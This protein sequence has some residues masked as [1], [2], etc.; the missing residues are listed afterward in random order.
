MLYI[1]TNRENYNK[2]KFVFETIKG[3]TIVLV[4][5]Q[6]TIQAEG[7]AFFYTKKRL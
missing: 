3:N 7:D 4:P 1:H 2:E 5:D 6:Y